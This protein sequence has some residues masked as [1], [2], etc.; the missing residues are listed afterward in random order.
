MDIETKHYSDGSSATGPAPLP[1]LSPGTSTI[2]M[3][4]DPNDGTRKPM[5]QSGMLNRCLMALRLEVPQVVA[6]DVERIVRAEVDRLSGALE[7]VANRWPCETA[8]QMQRVARE[9]LG[10]SVS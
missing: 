10:L 3:S 9:A 8:E 4:D 6:D 2:P 1:D 5:T 7:K